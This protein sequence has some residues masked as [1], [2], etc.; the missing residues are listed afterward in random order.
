M[1]KALL[2]YI[3]IIIINNT[4][5]YMRSQNVKI[6]LLITWHVSSYVTNTIFMKQVLFMYPIYKLWN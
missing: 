3:L 6:N 1:K 5:N 4:Y 2:K